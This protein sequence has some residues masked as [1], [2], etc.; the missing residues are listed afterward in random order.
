MDTTVDNDSMIFYGALERHFGYEKL[1]VWTKELEQ[2][3]GHSFTNQQLILLLRNIRDSGYYAVKCAVRTLPLDADA[4]T[5]K[6]IVD[7]VVEYTKG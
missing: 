7:S 1:E 4:G 5:I 3:A 2:E 6:E